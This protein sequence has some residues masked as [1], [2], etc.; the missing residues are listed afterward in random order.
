MSRCHR[1]GA[2]R[3]FRGALRNG[4]LYVKLG[5]GLCAFNHLLPP[6]YGAALR[7]LEDRALQ[8]RHGEVDELFLEEFRTTPAGLFREFDYEPVAAA[9]LAQVHRAQLH[10]GT[11]VAVKCPPRV[12]MSPG[13]HVPVS[14]H[15]PRVLVSPCPVSPSLH[16]PYVPVSPGPHVP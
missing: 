5:Q 16:V 1:R 10:D 9:S 6:E 13:P 4:G 12:P 11:P 8:R 14:P 2:E 7:P 3:L 15:V